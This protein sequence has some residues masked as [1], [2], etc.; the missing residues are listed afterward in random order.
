MRDLCALSRFLCF[1]TV[2]MHF[3]LKQGTVHQSNKWLVGKHQTDMET[4]LIALRQECR[5]AQEEG[6]EEAEAM[7]L[8]LFWPDVG[9]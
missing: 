5:E 9:A 7:S 6:E 1:P 2:P 4:M 8:D 3:V